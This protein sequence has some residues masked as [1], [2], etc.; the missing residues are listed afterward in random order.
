MAAS[1]PSGAHSRVVLAT[2]RQ[3]AAVRS[4]LVWRFGH[5]LLADWARSFVRLAG[6]W[7]TRLVGY[8]PR[9]GTTRGA[10]SP[11]GTQG[12]PS[13]RTARRNGDSARASRRCR[14]YRRNRP[15]RTS[16][17]VRATVGSRSWGRRGPLAP[18][19]LRR[20][21]SR[22]S[23][24]SSPRSV[25]VAHPRDDHRHVVPAAAR[26]GEVDE[27]TAAR[28]GRRASCEVLL[29]LVVGHVRR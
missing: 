11:P 2:S 9:P 8:R 12:M 18:Q 3:R 10:R 17:E 29:D 7:A 5:G 4:I 23:D 19:P 21:G 14:S 24:S 6:A 22:P 26:E 16:I 20:T 13:T 15:G 1:P 28:L 27:R 25:L